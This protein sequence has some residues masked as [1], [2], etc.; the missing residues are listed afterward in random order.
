MPAGDFVRWA[1][2]LLD[3]LGQLRLVADPAIARKAQSA[4]DLIRRGVV[5]WTE[6]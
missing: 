6:Y 1:K 5:A 3:V 2:I 4:A